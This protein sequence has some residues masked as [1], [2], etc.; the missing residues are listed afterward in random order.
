MGCM[1]KHYFVAITLMLLLLSGSNALAFQVWYVHDGDTLR[2]QNGQRIRLFGIDAPELAQPYG[3]AA[4]DYLQEMVK[5]Q[6]LSISCVGKSFQRLVCK[7]NAGD[8]D[9]GLEMV[10]AGFA[11]D[12]PKF[13]HGLYAQ[14]QETAKAEKKGFWLTGT[15]NELPWNYRRHKR[16]SAKQQSLSLSPFSPENPKN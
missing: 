1:R 10:K 2:L 8:K 11:Y 4:R 12:Y 13:S 3:Q 14:A 5:G 16:D 6:D 9:V 7:V 15:N